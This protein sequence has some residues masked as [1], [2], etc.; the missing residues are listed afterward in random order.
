VGIER[1]RLGIGAIQPQLKGPLLVDL[2]M[3]LCPIDQLPD[4]GSRSEA[5]GGHLIDVD[6]SN[7][8]LATA[9]R[10]M[11]LAGLQP[12]VPRELFLGIL[13]KN[14]DLLDLG[15]SELAGAD[16]KKREGLYGGIFANLDE[17]GVR[18]SSQVDRDFVCLVHLREI[19]RATVAQLFS[20]IFRSTFLVF[21]AQIFFP[22][23]PACWSG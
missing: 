16:Q 13:L 7:F 11:P 12:L 6:E 17:E 5:V 1:Q 2:E 22:R 3:A 4:G 21:G 14:E 8:N 9:V 18:V 10:V 19:A 23:K 20:P 15:V